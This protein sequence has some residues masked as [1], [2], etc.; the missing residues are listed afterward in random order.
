[1]P[2]G[3][4]IVSEAVVSAV[5]AEIVE[6]TPL[7]VGGLRIGMN[8]A[9][10]VEGAPMVSHRKPSTVVSLFPKVSSAVQQA[11]EAHGGIPVEPVHNFG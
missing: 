10:R 5:I 1:M 11:I 9:Q 2:L 7:H 3:D 4:A 6:P 8:V